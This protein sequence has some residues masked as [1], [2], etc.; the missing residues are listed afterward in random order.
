MSD[1]KDLAPVLMI[2]GTASSVGKS[3]LV[4]GLCRL[5]ARR[6]LR[7]APFKAQNMSNNA[8]VCPAGGEIGR[9]Q[10]AQAVAARVIPSVDMNPVLLKPQAG[11]V[12]VVVRGAMSGV[13]TAR[14]YFDGTRADLWPVVAAALDHLRSS[15]DLVIAEGAG[16]PAEINLRARDIVNMRVALH[17]GAEVLLVGDIDRGGVFAALLGTWDWLAHEERALVRGFVLNKFRGDAALL[18]PAPALLEERTGVP[19]RGVLPFIDDLRLPEEDAASLSQREVA[20]V[21]VDIAIIRL[22][23]LANFDEFGPLAIEPGVQVRFVSQSAELRAPDLVIL[24]GTKVT[25]PDLEW[26][27]ERGLADRI[28]WL[29][30]H[31]TPVLGICGGYQMLG[32]VVHDADGVESDHGTAGGLGLLSA[33]THLGAQKRLAHTR[34]RVLDHGFGCWR[35]LAGVAVEGYEIHVGRTHVQLSNRP[36]IE[37]DGRPEGSVAAD[38]PVAGTHMHG[39]FERPEP[40]HALLRGLAQSRGFEWAPGAAPTSDPYDV[41]ADVIERSVRLD[42]LRISACGAARCF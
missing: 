14:E 3:T 42:G 26:L 23:H 33:E 35:G 20:D 25:I 1:G 28:R 39:L 30:Q 22:P 27:V 40:R 29:A 21:S 10:F 12:Q 24:P 13:Q 4:A 41:L 6:G 8:A 19:V 38:L 16:S 9:A 7:V 2:Q 32:T 15:F 37:I 17:A 34:G 31:G 11:T 18:A 36:F 5:F